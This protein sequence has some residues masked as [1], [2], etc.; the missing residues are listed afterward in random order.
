MRSSFDLGR[1]TGKTLAVAQLLEPHL[2]RGE[3]VLVVAGQG[4]YTLRM[5]DPCDDASHWF[6]G[7][8]DD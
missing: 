1:R 5:D 3:P 7:E 8:R 2:L 6:G 4:W